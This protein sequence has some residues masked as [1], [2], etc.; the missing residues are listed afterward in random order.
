MYEQAVIWGVVRDPPCLWRE[1][2][3]GAVVYNEATGDTHRLNPLAAEMFHSLL[4]EPATL[5][6]LTE[7]VAHSIGIEIDEEL[8]RR[9][10]AVVRQLRSFGLL[11]SCE[12]ALP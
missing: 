5:P 1:W 7:R 6:Q 9:V 12:P 3:D 8:A 10:K 11:Y 2:A 4:A